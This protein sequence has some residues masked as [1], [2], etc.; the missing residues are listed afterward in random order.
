MWEIFGDYLYFCKSAFDLRVHVFGAM[1][2]HIHMI[3][4]APN[5]NLSA[6]MEYLMRETS[7]ET[8]RIADAANHLWGSRFYSSVIDSPNYFLHAYKY[9]YRNPSA[10]G[11]V[12]SAL[13]YPYSTLPGLLGDRRLLIPVEDDATLFSDCE[14]IVRW[15]DDPYTSSAAKCL[16]NALRRQTF[17][18][19]VDRRTRTFP[20]LG[21]LPPTQV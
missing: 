12:H 13:D 14:G 20:D 11:L 3:A 16:R 18:I 15:I 17:K 5:A 1:P 4:R 6:A 7:K 2:N 21:E 19:C 10:A 8:G 9:L